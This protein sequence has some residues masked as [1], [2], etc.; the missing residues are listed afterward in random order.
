M[1]SGYCVSEDMAC[2]YNLLNTLSNTSI[3][4]HNQITLDDSKN[5][6]SVFADENGVNAKILKIDSSG[7]ANTF[8][9]F[10]STTIAKSI[11]FSKGFIYFIDD[12]GSRSNYIF[13]KNVDGITDTNFQ[14][15]V[16]SDAC[17]LFAFNNFIYYGASNC[18]YNVHES[19]TMLPALVAGD[20]TFGYQN[21]A[22]LTAKFNSPTGMTIYNDV[23]YVV[24]SGNRCIRAINLRTNIVSTFAASFNSPL[25]IAID[26]VEGAMYVADFQIK[27]IHNGIVTI[28]ASEA[29][30]RAKG[31]FLIENNDGPP[32][33]YV[34]EDI[35]IRLIEYV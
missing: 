4:G 24:D 22:G 23:L 6:Y 34:S 10:T 14:L 30:S 28:V 3:M 26:S 25:D 18:I 32:T 5:I 19:L 2:F 17:Y 9:T 20:G 8:Y 27:K 16:S 1:F 12:D 15:V 33:I 13:R 29:I 11:T 31:L 35:H 21:G 7:K